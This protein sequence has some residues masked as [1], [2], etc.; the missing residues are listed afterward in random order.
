VHDGNTHIAA[1]ALIMQPYAQTNI[2]LVNQ[3]RHNGYSRADLKLVGDAYE[4]AAE[5]FA[6]RLLPSDRIFLAHVVRTASILT[7]LRVPAGVV[8]AGLLHNVYVTG[9]FGNASA[10]VS[11]ANRDEVRQVLGSEAEEYV[12]RFPAMNLDE[13]PATIRLAC[14]NPDAL[15]P[16]ERYLLKIMLAEHLEHLLDLD[17]LYYPT[18]ERRY[19]MGNADLAAYIAKNLGCAQ[20]AAELLEASRQNESG[21]SELEL[22]KPQTS[23][24]VVAPRSY[25]RRPGLAAYEFLRS[26]EE[27]SKNMIRRFSSGLRRVAK[28]SQLRCLTLNLTE[29]VRSSLD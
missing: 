5:L 9:D 15:G 11:A 10:D 16:A 28:S 6:G 29:V 22:R 7:T 13:K 24:R 23:Q 21:E 17:I 18:D 4:L 1:A 12:A 8:A 25:C 26:W 19:Y 2:Q 20:L 14:E 3:L 27:N